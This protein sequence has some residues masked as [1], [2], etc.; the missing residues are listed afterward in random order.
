MHPLILLFLG[1]WVTV[2]GALPFGL[3]NLS[4]VDVSLQHGSKRAM[5]IAHGAAL[6]E[7]LFGVGAM[8]TGGMLRD[9][10]QG[11]SIVNYVIIGVLVAGSL[12]FLFHK[13]KE[14]K[15]QHSTYSGFVKGVFMN[16][17]SFQVFLYWLIAIAFLHSRNLLD[18]GFISILIFSLG[19][20]L[21]KFLVLWIYAYL[22]TRIISKSGIL[23]Y[24]INRII[25]GI[26]LL[27][28]VY[29]VFNL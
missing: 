19:I 14:K 25:G 2:I 8:L 17:I 15:T 7:V 5:P 23:S 26:L 22:S 24:H 21:G 28:A 29:Q 1:I 16:L 27:I 20:W 18:T 6:V 11:N 3:V 4:V 12:V 9:F 10:I 13:K